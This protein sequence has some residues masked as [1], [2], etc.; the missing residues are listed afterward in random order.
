MI[1]R[2]GSPANVETIAEAVPRYG[3]KEF[4]SATR[5]T[6]PMLSLLRHNSDLFNEIIQQ[7]D[8]PLE[9]E[10][11]LEHTVRPQK[12]RGKASHSISA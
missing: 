6:V 1:I 11:I 7:L 3:R 4:E 2:F 9:Y 12:G 5:S 8:F 10:L